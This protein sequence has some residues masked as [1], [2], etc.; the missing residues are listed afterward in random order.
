MLG[1]FAAMT[2]MIT[3]EAV[4]HAIHD[5]FKGPVFTGS[6][7]DRNAAAATEAF[8]TLM[9]IR[10]A[11]NPSGTLQTAAT[12]TAATQ[13]AATQTA[14]TQTAATQTD[15]T[16]SDANPTAPNPIAQEPA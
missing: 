5:K 10:S 8:A 6:V 4:V 13:T 9:A 16:Q 15:A 12:Q 3:L 2:G 11:E 7:A 14:A 1:G